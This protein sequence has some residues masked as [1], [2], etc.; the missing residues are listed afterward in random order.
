MVGKKIQKE[1]IIKKVGE[2]MTNKKWTAEDY[3]RVA[4]AWDYFANA[5]T[6][7]QTEQAREMFGAPFTPFWFLRNK[8]QDLLTKDKGAYEDEWQLTIQLAAEKAKL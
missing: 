5:N 6:V 2:K 3:K 4:F 1:L 8:A 7:C